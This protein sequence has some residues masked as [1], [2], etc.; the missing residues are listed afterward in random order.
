MHALLPS[1]RYPTSQPQFG[2]LDL[3]YEQVTQIFDKFKQDT[4]Y[5][6]QVL[7]VAN[8]SSYVPIGQLHVGV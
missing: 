5:I 4:H 3:F 2:G 6:S 7:Q 1:K 8:P